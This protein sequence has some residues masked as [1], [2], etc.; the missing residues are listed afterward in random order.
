MQFKVSINCQGQGIS[1]VH[2]HQKVWIMGTPFETTNIEFLDIRDLGFFKYLLFSYVF[3]CLMRKIVT[4]RNTLG[5]WEYVWTR[6][7]FFFLIWRLQNIRALL[8]LEEYYYTLIWVLP[9]DSR[10]KRKRNNSSWFHGRQQS[11]S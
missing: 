8:N 4:N 10:K 2:E 6:A 1:Q 7:F 5:T 3:V 9:H 11:I